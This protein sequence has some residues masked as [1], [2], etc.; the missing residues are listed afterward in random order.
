MEFCLLGPLVVRCGGAVVPV[1]PG[2]QR[3]VLAALLLNARRVVSLDEL[4]EVLWGTGPPPSARV[5]LQNYVKR[6]RQSLG[7]AGGSRICTEP[8]GYQVV[9]KTGELDTFRF[10]ELTGSARAAVRRGAWDLAAQQARAALSLWRGE[11]LADVPSD[12]LSLREAPR[13]A[14]A[15]RQA[16]ETRI[17][18]DL[19]LGRHAEAIGELRRLADTDPLREHLHA[20][21]MLALYRDGRQAE[22][23]AAYT[24]APDVLVDELGTEPGTELRELQRRILSA[25]PGLADP[26]PGQRANSDQRRIVPRQLPGAVP[27]FTRR[28]A[29][30]PGRTGPP[31]PGTAGTVLISAIDGTAGVGKSALAVHWAHQVAGLFPD[32]QLYVNLRGYDPGQPMSPADALAGFLRTLGVSD[33]EIPAE[34]AERAA[35]YRSLLA[36]RR[37]LVLLDNASQVEQVRPLLPGAT[38]CVCLVTS[39]D[40]LAGLVAREGAGR[41]SLD[42]LPL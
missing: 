5:T 12:L 38:A 32:G 17:E 29:R 41:L 31:A 42:L 4:T 6:L 30:P 24:D 16:L 15:R 28:A 7:T 8:G 3:A 27:H 37:M 26:G 11:A 9:L 33:P 34:L 22:A 20:L 10:E 19:H 14:E 1:A 21:L 23:L 39:R 13:L 25:D 35:R 2:K 40:S 36:G 18:A